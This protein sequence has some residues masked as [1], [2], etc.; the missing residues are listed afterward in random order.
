MGFARFIGSVG[1]LVALL[2]A[3]SAGAA[4]AE[5]RHALLIGNQAY[6]GEIGALTNPHNDVALLQTTLKTLGFRVT[7]VRD[8]GLGAS[9]RAINRYLR[10]LRT[11]GKGAI[12]LF[13]YSG[14]GA[15]DG[16]TNYLIPVDATSTDTAELW[17]QSLRL[18][19]ITRRLRAEAGNATH[20][21]VFDACRNTLKLREPGKRAVVQAKGFRAERE[22]PGMLISY[23][24]AEGELASDLG[25]GAG[26]YAKALAEE[27]VMPGVEAVTMFRNVQRRVRA[28]IRQEPYLGFNA[29]GDVYFAGKEAAKPMAPQPPLG[30]AAQAWA[31]TK[32]TASEAVLEAFARRYPKTVFADLA[33]ARIAELKAQWQAKA[34]TERKLAEPERKTAALATAKPP[35]PPVSAAPRCDGLLL[36]D[37]VPV[38]SNGNRCIRPGS[39]E[40]FKDC[41]ECP[42][43]VVV[44]AGSFMMG[45]PE[46]E[47]GRDTNEGPLHRVSIAKP[48]AAGK[49]EIT[50][51]EWDACV[52]DG[53][54]THKPNDLGGGR[55]KRPVIN[56]TWNHLAEYIAWLSK[57]TGKSYR[58]LSEAEWEYAARAG[59]RT[60]FSTG[61]TI[62]PRQANF[63]PKTPRRKGTKS[64]HP[65]WTVEVGTFAANAFGLHDLHGNVYEWVGDCWNVSYEGAPDDGSVWASGD[66]AQRVYRGG[67]WGNGKDEI[68]SAFRNRIQPYLA[69]NALGFR[70]ARNL[71]P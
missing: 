5:A 66:C 21:V 3:C 35:A 26:P 38:G 36:G 19:E 23:A 41:P 13:Y 7:V 64:S 28:A 47:Q 32:D 12:G 2:A 25:D 39:G 8:A 49:F 56:V 71:S 20:F 67:S 6:T 34:G 48:F 30:E 61:S 53:G 58:L 10:A 18:G 55:G 45:S 33:R 51:D 50:F 54:C 37:D 60:P 24:T 57:V 52:A 69:G 40:S 43:M 29:L 17:D 16:A 65:N 70:V 59:T 31:V 68:R 15:A 4:H 1:C 63:D 44:P 27:I 46:S 11:A 14:H 62:S 42:E 22:E 9:N